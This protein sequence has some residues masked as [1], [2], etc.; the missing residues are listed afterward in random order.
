M[1][2]NKTKAERLWLGH[3]ASLGC[4]VCRNLG[5]GESPAEIHHVR[6]ATGMGKR[7]SHW[8]VIPLCPRHHRL[9]ADAYHA[10]P[11]GWER[12]FGKQADLVI[13]THADV[14]SMHSMT[15]GL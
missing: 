14:K 9:G 12:R 10:S 1:I 5:Y 4:A 2:K 6:I 7:S 11:A 15:V 3:V 13:Q 8:D